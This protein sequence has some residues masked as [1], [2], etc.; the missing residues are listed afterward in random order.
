MDLQSWVSDNAMKLMGLSES[1]MVDYIIATAKK[2]SSPQ[3]LY[4]KLTST[5]APDDSNTQQFAF[6]LFNR[7]P[8][9]PS[10][11]AAAE[12][13]QAEKEQRK[14]EQKEEA[15]LR[16]ASERYSL[17]LDDVQDNKEEDEEQKRIRKQ[18]KKLRKKRKQEELSDDDTEVKMTESHRY[19]KSNEKK[20]EPFML[21][22]LI[23]LLP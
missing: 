23:T 15:K 3:D 22:E 1:T 18:E 2:A 13:A 10:R 7:M 9:K 14:R 16:K 20:K 21:H 19:K 8:R 6:E 5:G 12:K 17:M 11:S 4:S